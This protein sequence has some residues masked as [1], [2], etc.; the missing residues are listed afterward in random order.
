MRHGGIIEETTSMNLT[1]LLARLSDNRLAGIYCFS[2]LISINPRLFHPI[3]VFWLIPELSSSNVARM[4]HAG[5]FWLFIF[6][7]FKLYLASYLAK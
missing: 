5:H 7:I 4:H 2:D 1:K 6:V 3:S